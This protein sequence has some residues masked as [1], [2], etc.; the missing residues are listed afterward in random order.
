MKIAPVMRAFERRGIDHRLIHTGQH[1]DEALSGAFLDEL[2]MGAPDISLGVGPATPTLQFSEIIAR[3]EPVLR[4]LR[5]DVVVVPGDVNSTLAG[6]LAAAQLGLPIAHVE[7]GLRSF[8]WAMPEE[9]N[10]V[11]TDR[12]SRWLFTHSPEAAE[13]LAREGIDGSRVFAV[14]NTM[15]DSLVAM[16]P[17]IEQA[18]EAEALDLVRDE[19][20]VV[21]L[22]RPSLVDGP[23]LQDALAALA[24]LAE[25]VPIIFPVHPRTRHRIE[26]LVDAPLGKIR[27]V[28]PMGYVAFLSLMRTSLGVLTD[29][30]GIQ[31]ETTFLGIP[32]CTLRDTTE[33]PVTVTSGTNV[34]LG[35]D[36]A[37]IEQVPDRLASA[38]AR[39]QT[40]PDGWDGLA[41]ERIVQILTP[42]RDAP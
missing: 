21:T 7:A 4:N 41:A 42:D 6:A 9:R 40:L 2:G 1:Y 28:G 11:L 32:C 38:R 15:I 39:R 17:Q 13:N 30:G 26:S 19:Y 33:R 16:L 27:L 22:H 31:E 20:I 5:P 35:L 18:R 25:T 8:D 24:R 29:S 37:A 3:L 23:R 36:L 34:L 14:G 10:R 12:L